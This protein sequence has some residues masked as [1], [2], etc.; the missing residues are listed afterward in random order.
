MVTFPQL[1]S[2]LAVCRTGS[3]TQA[4]RELGASQPTVSLQIKSLA[5]QLGAPLVE[6][7]GRGLRLT[8]AG[9]A[10][11]LYARDALDG[12][13]ALE[14]HVQALQGGGAGS[15]AVGASATAGGYILPSILGRF[16]VRFP[17]V[18]IRLQV[19]SPEHLFRDLS[20]G[21]LDVV[22]SVGVRTPAGLAVEA[23]CDEELTLVVSPRHPLARR[24]RIT[25]KDLSDQPLVTSLSGALFRELVEGKLRAAGVVPRVAIEARHPEAMKKLVENDMGYSLLFRPSVAEELKNGRLAALRLG[26]SPI[27]GQLIMACRPH[28]IPSPLVQQ[29]VHFVRAELAHHRRSKAPGGGQGA[30]PRGAR[31]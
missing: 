1:Q 17:K 28:R 23:L 20:T 24:R 26:G 2:F 5:R 29:F 9:N 31:S 8:P 11:R 4:A 6:R 15:L 25:A 10:L 16:R 13:R 22:L 3:L 7:D 19:D 14:Q 21:A 27:M 12:L 18:E 30:A